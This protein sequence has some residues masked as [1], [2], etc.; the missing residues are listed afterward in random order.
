M[1]PDVA[2]A[3]TSTR[4]QDPFIGPARLAAQKHT[5]NNATEAD[6]SAADRC[7]QRQGK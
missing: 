1:R 6:R 5:D 4:D 3:G 2:D 7:V